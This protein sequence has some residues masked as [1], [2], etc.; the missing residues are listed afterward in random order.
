MG[1]WV[2]YSF[3]LRGEGVGGSPK[4][5]IGHDIAVAVGSHLVL[6]PAWG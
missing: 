5:G 2:S 6:W 4:L 3:L 1:A